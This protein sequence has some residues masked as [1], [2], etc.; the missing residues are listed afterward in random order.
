MQFNSQTA[1][2][3]PVISCP[4]TLMSVNGFLTHSLIHLYWG[5]TSS[6]LGRR[7]K[8]ILHLWKDECVLK[9]GHLCRRNV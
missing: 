8:G 5:S 3:S 4:F 2:F 6:R 9:M 1:A 7:F